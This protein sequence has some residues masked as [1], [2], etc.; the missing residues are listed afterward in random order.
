MEANS[1]QA[2]APLGGLP[3]AQEIR[4]KHASRVTFHESIS[5][6]KQSTIAAVQWF[7]SRG[8]AN[9][10]TTPKMSS[11]TSPGGFGSIESSCQLNSMLLEGMLKLDAHS[12]P[13]RQRRRSHSSQTTSNEQ[14][15]QP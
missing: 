7:G 13:M 10:I 9:P 3:L 14:E 2:A 1:A 12:K 11:Q 8:S 4:L 6:Q 5:S 15:S